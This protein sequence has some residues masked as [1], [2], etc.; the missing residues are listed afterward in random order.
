[1]HP[2]AR[3]LLCGLH[4]A[5]SPLSI[6]MSG[7]SDTLRLVW[8]FFVASYRERMKSVWHPC[9][10]YDPATAAE[11]LHTDMWKAWCRWN[12]KHRGNMLNLEA[13]DSAAHQRAHM[14]Q[15]ALIRSCALRV[16]FRACATCRTLL[17]LL[18]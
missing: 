12:K 10:A 5:E 15:S 6:L 4:D 14:S 9:Y 2:V 17:Q 11:R 1:M 8:G 18:F 16:V 3:V 13:Y 7:P